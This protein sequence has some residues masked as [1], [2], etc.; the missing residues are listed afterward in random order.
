M[1]LHYTVCLSTAATNGSVFSVINSQILHNK[2]H[3]FMQVTCCGPSEPSPGSM[4]KNLKNKSKCN[5]QTFLCDHTIT[6]YLLEF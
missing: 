4:Y 2:T 1:L 3:I 5:I 6:V